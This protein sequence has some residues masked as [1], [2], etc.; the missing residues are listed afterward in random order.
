MLDAAGQ[1]LEAS[2]RRLPVGAHARC[3]IQAT[4]TVAAVRGERALLSH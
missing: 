3:V 4:H 2:A 1:A